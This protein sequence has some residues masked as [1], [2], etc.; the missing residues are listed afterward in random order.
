MILNDLLW[1]I[2]PPPPNSVQPTSGDYDF[3]IF[4]STLSEMAS[5]Y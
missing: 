5:F 4:K 1:E 2:G 3:D